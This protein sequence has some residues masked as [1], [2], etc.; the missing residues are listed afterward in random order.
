VGRCVALVGGV[1][2]T[3]NTSNRQKAHS[4]E[5]QGITTLLCTVTILG[6]VRIDLVS[7][8]GLTSQEKAAVGRLGDAIWSAY[9]VVLGNN[10]DKYKMAYFSNCVIH[11]EYYAK[12]SPGYHICWVN[13]AHDKSKQMLTLLVT[14]L[15]RSYAQVEKPSLKGTKVALSYDLTIPRL[16]LDAQEA[17]QKANGGEAALDKRRERI[18]KP[19][20]VKARLMNAMKEPSV[21]VD[22]SLT[23]EHET[24]VVSIGDCGSTPP[25]HPCLQV[26]G[27]VVK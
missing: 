12:Q 19:K 22:E 23:K 1:G 18:R 25:P 11:N 8:S 20:T 10:E 6:L 7:P 5:M 15:Q 17:K 16:F 9:S 2:T 27:G 26:I 4:S 21:T 13:P 14:D 3:V 24:F